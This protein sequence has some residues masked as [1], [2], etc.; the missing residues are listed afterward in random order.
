MDVY[1]Y[2]YI[3]IHVDV[4]YVYGTCRW[5][6]VLG[7]LPAFMSSIAH[8]FVHDTP[9]VQNISK[10]FHI[11]TLAACIYS[12][13]GRL[14]FKLGMGFETKSMRV[15]DKY[16][17]DGS[18]TVYRLKFQM[19]P[20]GYKGDYKGTARTP[21]FSL[22][23]MLGCLVWHSFATSV[24]VTGYK[25]DKGGYKGYTPGY[26]QGYSQ[27]YGQGYGQSYGQGFKGALP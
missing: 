11:C 19:P 7:H 1:I 20:S 18:C 27:G 4:H 23:R 22:C 24:F 10:H 16:M 5:S 14:M 21:C 2:I 3:I 9:R 15:W 8:I 6:C 13:C 12:L 26:S 25:G 17:R